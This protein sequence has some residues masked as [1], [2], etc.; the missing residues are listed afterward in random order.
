MRT[1]MTQRMRIFAGVLIAIVGTAAASASML[2]LRGGISVT[3]PALV[4]MIPVV[5]AVAV[6]GFLAGAL[7][8]A[9]SFLAYDFFFIQPYG[10]LAVGTTQGWVALGVE[11]VVLLVVARV[12]ASL[13]SARTEAR[14]REHESRQLLEL[15]ELLLGEKPL[16][17]LLGVVVSSVRRHF[18]LHGVVLLLP[19]DGRLEIAARDGEELSEDELA[20]VVPRSGATASL[21]V[22]LDLQGALWAVTLV[23]AERPVGLLVFKGRRP[24]RHEREMLAAYA[25]HGAL[26]IE[27]AQLREQA[28]RTSLLE[29][30]DSFRRALLGSVSH[31]LRTPLASIKASVSTLVNPATSA[32]IQESERAE[33]LATIEE[34]ADH[35]ARLVTNLLDMSRI[36]AGALVIHP[37]ATVLADA[38]DE[39]LG[40]LGG[41]VPRSQVTVQAPAGLPLLAVD[42]TLV[43]QVLVNLLEN[44]A[45][46]SPRGVAI[47]VRAR[48]VRGRDGLAAVEIAVDDRGAGVPASERESIFEM[49]QRREGGGRAGLGLGIAKAFVEAHGGSIR[50]EASRGGG[51]SFV[52]DMPIYSETA[53]AG[54]SDEKIR[55]AAT[56]LPGSTLH[57][58]PRALM[59]P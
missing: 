14:S 25:A 2:P 31:D 37:E 50:V 6:G 40:M 10:T 49:F 47:D 55:P 54:D 33:L 4:L 34:Q 35:L 8:V 28:L 30:T 51:A 13:T 16:G 12:V 1:V 57:G 53:G 32:A 20:H 42:H 22:L 52:F 11:V 27:R 41:L 24:G 23:S 36:E 56:A 48:V 44:A 38:V 9:F 5:A 29:E 19:V 46:H 58:R 45:R 7:G 3:I 18:N 26:A 43:T 39:A 15:L 17:E 21:S 59:A